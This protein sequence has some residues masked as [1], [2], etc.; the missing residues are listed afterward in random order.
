MIWFT[1]IFDLIFIAV[2]H[3]KPNMID[4]YSILRWNPSWSRG[5]WLIP[6]N[7]KWFRKPAKAAGCQSHSSGPSRGR[8]R[9]YSLHGANLLSLSELRVNMPSKFTAS[10][11]R[12]T[13]AFTSTPIGSTWLLGEVGRV[14]VGSHTT[15]VWAKWT[16]RKSVV[17]WW[18]GLIGTDWWWVVGIKLTHGNFAKFCLPM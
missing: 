8:R 4:Y 7:L 10:P 1:Q 12:W 18:E 6:G 14:L 2:S 3:P 11:L 5:M 13:A 17:L 9:R 15:A 16:F